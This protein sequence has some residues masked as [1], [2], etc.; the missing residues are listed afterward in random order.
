MIARWCS[1]NPS[2][3]FR[4]LIMKSATC[5]VVGFLLVSV[6]PVASIA[7]TDALQQYVTD[8]F[9]VG[10]A[11]RPAR[12]LNSDFAKTLVD[13]AGLQEVV[14]KQMQDVQQG[15]GFDLRHA[16]EVVMLLDKRTIFHMA[17]LPEE[18]NDDESGNGDKNAVS[19]ATLKNHLKQLG[20]AMHNFHDIYSRFATDDGVAEAG[21]GNL[22]WRVHLLPLLNQQALYNQ[23]HLDEAWDSDH[24][25]TLIEKMPT[26]YASN[27]VKGKGKTSVHVLTGE[28]ALFDG[29]V[30]PRIRDVL[31]GTSNTLLMVMAGADKAEV[32]TKP[33]GLELKVGA[34]QKTLGKVGREF[35]V[36]MADGFVRP[37]PAGLDKDTFRRLAQHQDG[38]VTQLEKTDQRVT[39][40]PTWIVRTDVDIDR[41]AVFA[42][43]KPMRRSGEFK[44]AEG[45]IYAYGTYA[46]AFPDRRTLLA[47]PSDLMPTLLKAN[48]KASAEMAT[49]L[50]AGAAKNDIAFV[51]DLR[52]LKSLKDQLAGNLPMAGVVQSVDLLEASLDISGTSDFLQQL[53]VTTQNAASA[54]QLSALMTG[55]MHMQKAQLM[56]NAADL[57]VPPATTAALTR[58]MD[59]TEITADGTTVRYRIPKP[60]DMDAFADELKGLLQPLKAIGKQPE[61]E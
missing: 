2:A 31:D 34:P 5:A 21:K 15:I 13:D 42:S 60:D 52:S 18:A 36:C 22:S 25:K 27:G 50:N 10:L 23:F 59:S 19:Q 17:G 35:M 24:N 40:L 14:A 4:K 7:Q 53:T 6:L 1:S 32:W 37:L 44:I 51:A 29:D 54:A 48:G 46:V 9:V 49:R 41:D 58:L 55:V 12:L 61:Q 3:L 28:G 39:R 16:V 20:L 56:A 8:D 33:G 38:E 45:T 11:F 43:L 57:P 26:V 47:A 30:A